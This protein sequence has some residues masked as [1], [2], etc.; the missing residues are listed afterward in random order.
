MHYPRL[1]PS[2]RSHPP[3]STTVSPSPATVR[4]LGGS[5]FFNGNVVE[6]SR[7]STV[8]NAIF[9]GVNNPDEDAV[10]GGNRSSAAS[11]S[12]R[13]RLR[14]RQRQHRRAHRHQRR[15]RHL[16]R[17]V[18]RHRGDHA[19]VEPTD[20]CLVTPN[21]RVEKLAPCFFQ[22]PPVTDAARRLRGEIRR[23]HVLA[24]RL[25]PVHQR[26][27]RPLERHDE[28]VRDGRLRAIP[29]IGGGKL[30]SKTY[31]FLTSRSRP[32]LPWTRSSPMP[33][34][35]GRSNATTHTGHRRLL[36]S[37]TC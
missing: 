26:D 8:Q 32:L 28:R 33:C 3:S 7:T 5:Q 12:S 19:T 16:K 9:V 15:Q 14:Q 29:A 30:G 20:A 4:R 25:Q 27:D 24:R 21:Q 17:R 11:T 2:P 22:T 13:R 18:R 36:G 31:H 6:L 1:R 37:V 10:A 35:P 34:S 23:V